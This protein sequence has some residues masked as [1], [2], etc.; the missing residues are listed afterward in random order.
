MHFALRNERCCAQLVLDVFQQVAG[1][2]FQLAAERLECGP[3]NSLDVA[4]LDARQ[5]VLGQTDTGRELFRGHL[6]LGKYQAQMRLYS[7]KP[8]LSP[9]TRR[10]ECSL[11]ET[12]HGQVVGANCH[13]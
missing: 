4:R 5:V 8:S 7:H 11:H 3:A 1:L 13:R 6:S 9:S 2:A 10:C 12:A